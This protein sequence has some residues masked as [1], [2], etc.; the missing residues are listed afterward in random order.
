MSAGS[1]WPPS[2]TAPFVSYGQAYYGPP[3]FHTRTCACSPPPAA[4]T[5]AIQDWK[6]DEPSSWK[7]FPGPKLPPHVQILHGEDDKY[8]FIETPAFDRKTGSSSMAKKFFNLQPK[9]PFDRSTFACRQDVSIASLIKRMGGDPE[10]G[11]YLIEALERG[12]GLFSPAQVL[13]GKGE[14]GAKKASDFGFTD[15]RGTKNAPVWL[16]LIT[17]KEKK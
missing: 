1:P 16:V 14:E 2:L 6:Q 17:V 9:G 8:F 11:D 12:H 3:V 7:R 5:T 10:R 15:K 13:K 4:T